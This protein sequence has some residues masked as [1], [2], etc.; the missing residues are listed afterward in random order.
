MVRMMS[1]SIVI[2]DLAIGLLRT[3]NEL[4]EP[5]RAPMCRRPMSGGLRAVERGPGGLSPLAQRFLQEL[6]GPVQ[7]RSNRGRRDVPVGREVVDG[8][9]LGL[10]ED[11]RLP[12]TRRE[13][14]DSLVDGLA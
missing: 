9:A 13:P 10:D 8:H 14:P 1:P 6:L 5:P 3:E 11:E 4:D 2:E 12:K 7:A